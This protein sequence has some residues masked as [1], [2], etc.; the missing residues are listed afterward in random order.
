[1][2]GRETHNNVLK[3]LLVLGAT[4]SKFQNKKTPW[5]TNNRKKIGEKK[6]DVLLHVT[7]NAAY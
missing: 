5:L 6:G 7:S 4:V 3:W 2:N 1:M